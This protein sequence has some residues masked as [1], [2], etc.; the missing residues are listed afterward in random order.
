MTQ[1]QSLQ[2][3]GISTFLLYETILLLLIYFS[4]ISSFYKGNKAL[5]HI[6]ECISTAVIC[7]HFS[8]FFYFLAGKR[9]QH[10]IPFETGRK[11]S[12]FVTSIKI[13]SLFFDASDLYIYF[14]VFCVFLLLYLRDRLYLSV[15]NHCWKDLSFL[16]FSAPRKND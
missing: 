10:Q 14:W 15:C 7:F 2:L 5:S 11:A 13:Y 9:G 6:T 12:G 3:T 4:H 8:S 1:T 16:L